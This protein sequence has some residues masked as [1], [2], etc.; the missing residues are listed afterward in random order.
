MFGGNWRWLAPVMGS[1]LLGLILFSPKTDPMV[2]FA[3]GTN[4]LMET[5]ALNSSS[6]AAYLAE[7]FHSKQNTLD[8]D[9]LEWTYDKRSSSTTGSFPVINTNTLL[10]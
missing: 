4:D 3:G 1:F 7:S 5:L 8:R 2:Y 6:R 10:R 9:I